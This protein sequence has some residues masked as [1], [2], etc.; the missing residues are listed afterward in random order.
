MY[1]NIRMFAVGVFAVWYLPA[2]K[3]A[4]VGDAGPRIAA[5]LES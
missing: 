4:I 5:A 2:A 3:A 1:R